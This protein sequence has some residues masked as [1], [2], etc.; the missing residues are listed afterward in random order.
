MEEKMEEE[1][2][3]DI[4]EIMMGKIKENKSLEC[5]LLF[6]KMNKHLCNDVLYTDKK[7]KEST[8]IMT[9]IFNNLMCSFIREVSDCVN[10]RGAYNHDK[11][12]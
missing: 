12:Q 5:E 8:I 7:Y 9:H 2:K 11:L 3:I 4:A 10:K 6:M 1:N